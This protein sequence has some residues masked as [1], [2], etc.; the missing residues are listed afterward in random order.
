MDRQNS[1]V[2]LISD[3]RLGSFPR[4][5]PR[6]SPEP[7][8]F[9]SQSANKVRIFQIRKTRKLEIKPIKMSNEV[10]FFAEQNA[11]VKRWR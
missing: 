2:S 6:G 9:V 3:S 7:H 1:V 8:F 10:V 5:I 4:T 11:E